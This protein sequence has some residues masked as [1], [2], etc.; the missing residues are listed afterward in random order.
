M[1]S[2]TL[3]VRPGE[4]RLELVLDEKKWFEW[5][6][7]K[8]GSS[9]EASSAQ[10]SEPRLVFKKEEP[11]QSSTYFPPFTTTLTTLLLLR[12]VD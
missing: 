9:R 11:Y 5:R 12:L 1:S 4:I 2:S 3:R 7:L 8:T 10:L 6:R